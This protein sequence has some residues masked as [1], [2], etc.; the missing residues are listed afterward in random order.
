MEVTKKKANKRKPSRAQRVAKVKRVLK[1]FVSWNG[2]PLTIQRAVV[3]GNFADDGVMLYLGDGKWTMSKTGSCGIDG[4]VGGFNIYACNAVH[5]LRK[6][7]LLTHADET[8]FDSWFQDLRAENE[9][10]SELERAREVAEK[11]GFVL[12]KKRKS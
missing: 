12:R 9:R 10:A 8:A 1:K 3:I 5:G 4:I 6:L 7:R 11:H 2:E